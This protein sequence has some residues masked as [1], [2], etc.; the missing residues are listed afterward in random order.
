VGAGSRVAFVAKSTID[1]IALFFAL[2]R[3]KAVACPISFRLP[4]I[5][6]R[7]QILRLAPHLT[8]EPDKIPL[9]LELP[10]KEADIDSSVLATLLFTSG[11]TGPEKIAGHSLENHFANARAVIARLNLEKSDIWHLALPLF[12]VGGIAT[13][14]RC[15]LT[16]S[17]VSLTSHCA[18]ILSLVPT[19]LYRL[20]KERSTPPL[21]GAILGGAPLSVALWKTASEHGFKIFTTYGMTEMSSQITL[22]LAP[23]ATSFGLTSGELLRDRM[24]KITEEGEIWVK[25]APLFLGYYNEGRLSLPLKEEGWFATGDLG[26]WT[27]KGKL[28]I[29]GRMDNMFISGGENILPEEIERALLSLPE[30]LEA[31]VLPMPDPE[32][33]ARPIAYIST[34]SGTFSEEAI[35]E[36]LRAS[37]P[38]IKLPVRILPLSSCEL[39]IKRFNA[40]TLRREDAHPQSKEHLP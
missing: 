34:E 12:H 38:G 21:K 36:R 31:H 6:L 3:L 29:L 30:M 33:G 26:E 40:K 20:C 13:L 4:E 28:C 1:T 9:T 35:R 5:K 32:F 14:M 10:G 25:G 23:E 8:I 18:T 16:G 19:Q 22:D 37:L 24:L 39:K 2:F 15:F 7:E 17:C 11:S 27:E